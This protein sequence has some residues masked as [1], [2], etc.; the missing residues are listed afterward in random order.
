MQSYLTMQKE[1]CKPVWFNDKNKNALSEKKQALKRFREIATAA[2]L[3]KV[4]KH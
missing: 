1:E 4:L 3:K 2:K